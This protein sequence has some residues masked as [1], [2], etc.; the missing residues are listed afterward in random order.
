[1]LKNIVSVDIGSSLIKLAQLSRTDGK[2]RLDKVT[3]ANNPIPRLGMAGEKAKKDTLAQAI[4]SSLKKSRIKA[5]DAVSSLAGS[6]LIIQYFKFPPLLEKDLEGTVKLEAERIMSDRLAE[7]DTDFQ[8]LSP[9]Q[10]KKKEEDILFV[11]VPKM[12]VGHRLNIL[13]EA[14]LNPIAIDI[15]FMALANCFLR[16]KKIAS[17]QSVMVLNLGAKLV[18]LAILNKIKPKLALD[19]W[20]IFIIIYL[21]Q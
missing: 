10:E 19:K 6:S 4:K 9:Y 7:M 8:A 21:I 2:V 5:N 1:M 15:D 16:L 11:A 14:G 18:N 13:R 17:Q 3:V 20:R 12:I